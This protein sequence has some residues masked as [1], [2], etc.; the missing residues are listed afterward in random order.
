[1]AFVL[2]D[3]GPC[4]KRADIQLNPDEVQKGF[5]AAYEEICDTIAL[6]G[7]RKGRIPRNIVAKKFSKNIVQEVKEKLVRKSFFDMVEEQ[8]LKLISQPKFDEQ[9]REFSEGAEFSFSVSFEVQPALALP[10]YRKIPLVKRV[11]KVV[12]ADLQQTQETLLKSRTTYAEV[13][14]PIGEADDVAVL[15]LEAL[16]S[17]A[18]VY[19]SHLFPCPISAEAGYLDIFPIEN[20][21]GLLGGLRKGHFKE[22]PFTVPAEF[23]VKAELAG[24]KLQLKITVDGV[25][26]AQV[27]EFGPEFMQ[28]LGFDKEEDYREA[29]RR[30]VERELEKRAQA[31]LKR[32]IYDYFDA[33]ISTDLPEETVKRHRDYLVNLRLVSL[34]RAGMPNEQA[35]ARRKEFEGEAF[36]EARREIKVGFALTRIAE[37]EKVFVTEREVNVRVVQ[38]AQQRGMN[39]E[40]LREELEKNHELDAL[41]GQIKEEKVLDLIIKKA[42]IREEEFVRAEEAGVKA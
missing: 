5:N 8:K 42:D 38:L 7:F 6:P 12:E 35:E 9:E 13:E 2:T 14:A 29:L 23:P 17:G 39:P 33:Q 28:S 24:K 36:Q 40:K 26:R 31:E 15:S 27:P 25:R 10:E 18:N 32:Q 1:M 20:L 34:M 22:I 11:K 37:E 4:R 41:R 19:H 30:G 21:K 3:T 16:E